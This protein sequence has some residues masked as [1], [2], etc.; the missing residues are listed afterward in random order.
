MSPFKTNLIVPL[1]DTTMKKNVTHGVERY[2]KNRGFLESHSLDPLP[3][4]L[5]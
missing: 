4:E 2:N 1:V 5:A 3:C